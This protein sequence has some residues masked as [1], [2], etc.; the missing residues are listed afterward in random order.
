[1]AILAGYL[2][3]FSLKEIGLKLRVLA[4]TYMNGLKVSFFQCDQPL[5]N[6]T[7]AAQPKAV[8]RSECCDQCGRFMKLRQKY[9]QKPQFFKQQSAA[10][11]LVKTFF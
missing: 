6:F 11:V 3:I 1:M 4:K 10:S 7:P 2:Y 5:N 8:T 9:I